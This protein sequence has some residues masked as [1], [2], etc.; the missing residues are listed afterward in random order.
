MEQRAL[1]IGNSDGVGL[2]ITKEL[3]KTDWSVIGISR[4][5]SPIVHPAYTHYISKVQ[6]DAYIELLKSI[7][8]K[9][10]PFDLCI[11]C[12]GIGELL[13]ITNMEQEIEIFEVNLL[14]MIKTAACIIPKMVKQEAGHF[15]G[16]SSFADE[17]LSPEAPSYHASKAGFSNYL[18]SLALALKP[19]GVVVTN[20]RFGFI[21]TKM[22]K[23]DVKPFMMTVEQATHHILKC[24]EKKPMR[25]KAPKIMIPLIKLRRIM[26]RMKV[27]YVFFIL[28]LPFP[29]TGNTNYNYPFTTTVSQPS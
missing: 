8:Q 3:L 2:S 9:D 19:R 28:D 12:A 23:G 29:V 21:D 7:V 4:S 6:K 22:A 25:Y 17:M 11:Y 13:D 1:I 24:I 20:I 14:G 27:K 10:Q 5:K 18:E 15:I 16:L 26:L